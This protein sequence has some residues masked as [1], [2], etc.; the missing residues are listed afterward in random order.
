MI[1]HDQYGASGHRWSVSLS[2]SA[3]LIFM[4]PFVYQLHPFRA[5]KDPGDHLV[6][7]KDLRSRECDASHRQ[8]S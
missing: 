1:G 8:G 7:L 6:V 2:H 5:V 3:K 4:G